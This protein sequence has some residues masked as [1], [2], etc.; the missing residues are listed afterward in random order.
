M[1]IKCFFF[2][3]LVLP[4]HVRDPDSSK[5]AGDRYVDFLAINGIYGRGDY[6]DL[7]AVYVQKLLLI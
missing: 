1:E 6:L 3:P 2:F 4:D 7:D 5:S